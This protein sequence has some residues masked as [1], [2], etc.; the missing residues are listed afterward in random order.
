MEK[1]NLRGKKIISYKNVGDKLSLANNTCHLCKSIITLEDFHPCKNK[2]CH[3]VKSR[4]SKNKKHRTKKINC[5]NKIFCMNCYKNHFPSYFINSQLNTDLNCPSCAGYCSC[6]VC[7]KN[8]EKISEIVDEENNHKTCDNN[9]VKK[10]LS[11]KRKSLKYRR[12]IPN[13]D[14]K[15]NR[16]GKKIFDLKNKIKKLFPNIEDEIKNEENG[17]NILGSEIIVRPLIDPSEFEKIK[18]YNIKLSQLN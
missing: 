1:K 3:I 18:E 4:N 5:C 9:G 8:K 17:N 12:D 16:L 6:K 14:M 7:K 10:L 15:K 11:K 2:F 13:I